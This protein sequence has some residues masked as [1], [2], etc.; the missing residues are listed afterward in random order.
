MPFLT[1]YSNGVNTN[2]NL[3]AEAAQLVADALGKPI[4]YVVVNVV[5]NP[6]MAFDGS[7]QNKGALIEMKSVGFRDK[8]ALAEQLTDFVVANLGV[9]AG[10]VNIQFVDMPADT[11]AI[12]GSVLG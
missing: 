10:L 2:K 11:V 7:A 5:M 12:A 9:E 1:I 4:K 3:T 6:A 8:N